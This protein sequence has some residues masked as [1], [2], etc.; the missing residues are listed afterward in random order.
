[1]HSAH[2]HTV[3]NEAEHQMR[4]TNDQEGIASI[5]NY[6]NVGRKITLNTDMY[7]YRA[8]AVASKLHD[9]IR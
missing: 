8:R 3:Y 1:M 6:Y 7:I 9:R 2:D 4:R 5:V